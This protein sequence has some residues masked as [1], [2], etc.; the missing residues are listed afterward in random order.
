[1]S[2][3]VNWS[4]GVCIGFALQEITIRSLQHKGHL[5]DHSAAGRRI[6][7]L[8]APLLGS[9][10]ILL[11]SRLA[12]MILSDGTNSYFISGF[13]YGIHLS[14]GYRMQAA[15]I[16]RGGEHMPDLGISS[17]AKRPFIL[18]GSPIHIAR[19]R[20]YATLSHVAVLL[21]PLPALYVAPSLQPFAVAALSFILANRIENAE[22]KETLTQL[23]ATHHF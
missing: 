2:I 5:G 1:M 22:H 14:V 11:I 8:V 19:P 10:L 7:S 4:A 21:A 18:R 3:V 23:T 17:G 9:C 16:A 20:C 6:R 12:E 15:T 13:I